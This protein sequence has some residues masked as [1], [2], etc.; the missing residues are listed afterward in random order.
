MS[1]L[2]FQLAVSLDGY[3]AGPDQ[4]EEHPLGVGGM[5]LHEWVFELEAWR[6]QQGQEGGVVNASTPVSRSCSRTSARPSWAA[7]CSGADP[8]PGARTPLGMAGGA[9][10]RPFTRRSSC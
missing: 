8:A 5:A 7:T 1:T 9:T 4:S 6:K 3:V 10:I 2:R